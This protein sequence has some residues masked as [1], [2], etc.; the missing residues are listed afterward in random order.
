MGQKTIAGLALVV[1]GGIGLY[2]K[3]LPEDQQGGVVLSAATQKFKDTGVSPSASLNS[4]NSVLVVPAARPA[5][6]AGVQNPCDQKGSQSKARD[7]KEGIHDSIHAQSSI[8]RF[9]GSVQA[10][11]GINWLHS[12]NLSACFHGDAG[13][14]KGRLTNAARSNALT[15]LREGMIIA[16]HS[17]SAKNRYQAF[18]DIDRILFLTRMNFKEAFSED[19]LLRELGYNTTTNP[20]SEYE[21]ESRDILIKISDTAIMQMK[22]KYGFHSREMILLNLGDAAKGD[23]DLKDAHRYLAR[24]VHL[25]APLT[26][27]RRSLQ[28][29]L[30]QFFNPALNRSS[31]TP[32]GPS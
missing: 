10:F 20:K 32:A 17:E 12:N 11:R 29:Q 21:S 19:D 2:L 1:L 24:A 30:Q 27:E 3:S 22:E 14:E 15:A 4:Q 28:N 16:R 7:I 6:S 9:L 18:E 8:G 26:N 5:S 13:S 25:G 23:D 31:T